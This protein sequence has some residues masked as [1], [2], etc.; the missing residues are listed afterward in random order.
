MDLQEKFNSNIYL[1]DTLAQNLR[2]DIEKKEDIKSIAIYAAPLQHAEN[3]KKHDLKQQTSKPQVPFGHPQ[4]LVISNKI[5][6]LMADDIKVVIIAENS[7]SND[8]LKH[9]CQLLSAGKNVVSAFSISALSEIPEASHRIETAC[10]EGKTT[11]VVT[12]LFP[13]FMLQKLAGTLAYALSENKFT[14]VSQYVDVSELPSSLWQDIQHFGFIESDQKDIHPILTAHVQHLKTSLYDL[15]LANLK[16]SSDNVD[17]KVQIDQ[18]STTTSS[19]NLEEKH[20]SIQAASLVHIQCQFLVDSKVLIQL[21]EYWYTNQEQ[22]ETYADLP[23]NTVGSGLSYQVC[24]EGEPSAI[25]TQLSF[26]GDGGRCPILALQSQLL[27]HTAKTTRSSPIGICTIDAAPHYQLD[28]RI[29]KKIIKQSLS[30]SRISDDLVKKIVIW[31]PGEIGGAVVREALKRPNLKIV[32]AKVFSPHKN[33]KDLGALVGIAPLG[34]L[35]TTSEQD[36]LALD[37][38]CVIVT[39]QPKAIVEGLDEQVLALLT[40]GKNV[41]TSAAY[42]NVSMPN[43]LVSAQKPSELLDEIADIH[44]LENNKTEEIALI[45]QKKIWKFLK[46]Y[47]RLHRL[48]NRMLDHVCAPILKKVLPL[49]ASA[50]ALHQACQQGNSSL[51]GTGV[52]PSFMAERVGLSFK[53]LF[54]KI[55]HMRFIEAVDFSFMPDGMWGGLTTI[56]F[57]LPISEL[58]EDFIVARAGDFYY[59]DVTG[60]VAH[61]L[62]AVDPQKVKVVRSF[63]GIPATESFKVGSLIIKKGHAMA[64]H[65]VHKGYIDGEHFFTNEECWYLGPNGTFRGENLP[66]GSFNTPISYTLEIDA[67]PAKLRMQLSLDGRGKFEDI[68]KAHDISTADQRCA[69]GQKFKTE[70]VTNPITNATATAILDAVEAVCKS[71]AGIVIDDIALKLKKL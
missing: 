39:P 63:R 21:D 69:L 60:N 64:L 5:E 55:R 71:P 26:E 53:P 48:N 43:W 27:L 62:Y 6:Q 68:L 54:S 47:P 2:Q 11:F 61:L 15:A 16:Q 7:S 45:A 13:Y 46:R 25:Q 18:L 32:G 51:H 20:D 66:F 28:S 23:F 67:A 44:G 30:Q 34:I 10:Q 40:S 38:D 70:G 8:S 31:G 4:T 52:H 57:G 17:L 33:G 50:H 49:R 58:N 12:G 24:V 22:L 1:H 3:K 41:I 19:E 9:I 56:G 36:I 29:N 14:Q 37:A 59:G 65:M 42:H 35:A